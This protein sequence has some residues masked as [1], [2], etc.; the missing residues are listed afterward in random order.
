MWPLWHWGFD[1]WLMQITGHSFPQITGKPV[2]SSV[3]ELLVPL[4]W[5]NQS[6]ISR[7]LGMK[8]GDDGFFF[9]ITINI[10]IIIY[11]YRLIWKRAPSIPTDCHI[12]SLSKLPKTWIY[13]QISDSQRLAVVLKI[14][15]SYQVEGVSTA[16]TSPMYWY[17]LFL[18]CLEPG[19]PRVE[20]GHRLATAIQSSYA[21]PGKDGNDRRI[22]EG[23]NHQN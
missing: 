16:Q 10:S 20:G 11:K 8:H 6:K 18:R 4:D 17:F 1:P 13:T 19:R 3:K 14:A 5:C 21:R 15:S 12:I 22:V 23:G 9:N 2:R 7:H